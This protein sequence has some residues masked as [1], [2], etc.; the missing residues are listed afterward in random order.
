[1]LCPYRHTL[2]Y[3][4]LETTTLDGQELP[5]VDEIRYLGVYIVCSVDNAKRY[6]YR[7][8]SGIFAKVGR[9]ASEDVF[10]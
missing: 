1:M 6:F 7:T 3:A 2:Q 10:V 5:W 8:S 4:M 9:L